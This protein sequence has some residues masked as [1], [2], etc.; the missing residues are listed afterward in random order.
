MLKKILRRFAF[1]TVE[2]V[3]TTCR[4]IYNDFKLHMFSES[5]CNSSF[6]AGHLHATAERIY[7]QSFRCKLYRCIYQN[8]TLEYY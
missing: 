6:R 2:I 8:V 7:L 4:T 3:H 5:L 1:Q